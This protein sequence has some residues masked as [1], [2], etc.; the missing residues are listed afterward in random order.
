MRVIYNGAKS[1]LNKIMWVPKMF[2]SLYIE[3]LLKIQELSTWNMDLDFGEKLFN[4]MAPNKLRYSMY[5]D[6][7]PVFKIINLQS[8]YGR[9]LIDG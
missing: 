4:F 2:R 9:N 1:G 8:I 3:G 7:T 5:I 6:L